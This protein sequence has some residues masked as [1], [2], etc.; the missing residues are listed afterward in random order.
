MKRT[1]SIFG[2]TIAVAMMAAIFLPATMTLAENDSAQK[3]DVEITANTGQCEE[4]QFNTTTKKIDTG[5]ED[6]VNVVNNAAQMATQETQVAKK[7]PTD[8][9]SI[10]AN[11]TGQDGLVAAQ[12]NATTATTAQEVGN[13]ICFTGAAQVTTT[14]HLVNQEIFGGNLHELQENIAC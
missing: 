5:Q 10:T 14:M 12:N 3:N 1:K 4:A 7:A 6:T 13:V 11:D 2:C 8:N 9:A